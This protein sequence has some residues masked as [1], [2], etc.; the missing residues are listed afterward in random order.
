[1]FTYLC[2]V[3]RIGIGHLI[4][5]RDR[6]CDLLPGEAC[7]FPT[8]GLSTAPSASATIL[9]V[10]CR[11]DGGYTPVRSARAVIHN[12]T[13]YYKLVKTF[14]HLCHGEWTPGGWLPPAVIEPGRSGGMQSESAG[15]ATGTEG[16][17]KYDV[18]F[19]VKRLGMVYVYWDNP[20]VGVTHP[21]LTAATEISPR[22]ARCESNPLWSFAGLGSRARTR[23]ASSFCVSPMWQERGGAPG[24]GQGRWRR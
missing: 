7:R 5:R 10:I 16:Y 22:T 17:A 24:V 19:G 14:D 9:L 21:R 13:S 1:M 3:L 18:F 12:R 15:T 2:E 8:A 23:R 11:C 4:Q 6:E 20:F